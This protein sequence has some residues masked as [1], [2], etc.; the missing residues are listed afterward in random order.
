MK[1]PCP[2]CGEALPHTLIST[3]AARIA[4]ASGRGRCKARTRAQ[5]KAAAL[6]RWGTPQSKR[7]A[8]NTSPRSG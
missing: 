3:E 6:A 1:I 7:R 4:G 2:H 5:A 8:R